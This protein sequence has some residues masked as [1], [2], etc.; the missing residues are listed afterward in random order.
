MKI[1]ICVL[2]A[3]ILVVSP[4][5]TMF[6]ATDP[7]S[8][9]SSEN[10]FIDRIYDLFPEVREEIY[11]TLND[12]ATTYKIPEYE[13]SKSVN[14]NDYALIIYSDDTIELLTSF[15]P[16]KMFGSRANYSKEINY[17]Y[18]Q[19]GYGLSRLSLTIYYTYTG[20]TTAPIIYDKYVTGSYVTVIGSG[21][22]NSGTKAYAYGNAYYLDENT[23][24]YPYTVYYIGMYV[25]ATSNVGH[26][27]SID[28]HTEVPY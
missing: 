27:F 5:S 26:S 10:T 19:P 16:V 2:L 13:Y 11:L 25:S 1:K 14:G 15:A 8:A 4:F 9:A 21:I 23:W 18:N 20:A 6:A 12:E 7:D 28:K 17:D 24:P 3:I 22:T